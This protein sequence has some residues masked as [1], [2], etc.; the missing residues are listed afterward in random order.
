MGTDYENRLL[1]RIG[2]VPSRPSRLR[3]RHSLRPPSTVFPPAGRSARFPLAIFESWGRG[4]KLLVDE[5]AKAGLPKP[6][7]ESDGRFVRVVFARPPRT[8]KASEVAAKDPEVALNTAEV[9]S[10]MVEA[11]GDTGEIALETALEL[12]LK[13]AGKEISG[14]V[15]AHCLRTLEEFLRH[16]R[17]TLAEVAVSVGV[18]ART[19]DSYVRLLQDIGILERTGARKAG[20]WLVTKRMVVGGSKDQT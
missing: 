16:P 11:G 7:I 20:S 6:L 1:F 15:F 17:A 18:S 3:M 4:I 9:A 13:A 12:A 5:C 2:S 8:G 19:V 14:K 10:N